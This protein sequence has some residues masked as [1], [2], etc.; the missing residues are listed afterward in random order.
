VLPFE[1]GAVTVATDL[2]SWRPGEVTLRVWKLI[3]RFDCQGVRKCNEGNW[4][5]CCWSTLEPPE[6]VLSQIASMRNLVSP[7]HKIRTTKRQESIMETVKSDAMKINTFHSICR[8]R[9]LMNLQQMDWERNNGSSLKY[10]E[11]LARFH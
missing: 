10:L 9:E 8:D 5:V 3:Q 11:I 4:L 1:G 6:R 7:V 2:A